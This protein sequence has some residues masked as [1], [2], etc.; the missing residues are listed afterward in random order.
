MPIQVGTSLDRI[1]LFDFIVGLMKTVGPEYQMPLPAVEKHTVRG[2]LSKGT[3]IKYD[4]IS[5]SINLTNDGDW[6]VKSNITEDTAEVIIPGGRDN[7]AHRSAISLILSREDYNSGQITWQPSVQ[8]YGYEAKHGEKIV[9]R[10]P[11]SCDDLTGTVWSFDGASVKNDFK[12]VSGKQGVGTVALLN[13]AA[14][15]SND[16]QKTYRGDF[17]GKTLILKKH[18]YD[19]G[20][21]LGVQRDLGDETLNM[22]IVDCRRI[23]VTSTYVDK[24]GPPRTLTFELTR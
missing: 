7:G 17:D 20:A 14:L 10:N 9:L 6:D 5:A 4:G 1:E 21:A 12:F 2:K 13:Y 16:D 23:S 8:L 22:K 11:D 18:A 19:P 24:F 3:Q 15:G